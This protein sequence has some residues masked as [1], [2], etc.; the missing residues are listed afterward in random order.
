MDL[1]HGEMNQANQT[2]PAILGTR[3]EA[4]TPSM[5]GTDPVLQLANSA[6]LG[7]IAL[8]LLLLGASGYLF[9]L[10]VCKSLARSGNK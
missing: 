3:A 9:L 4:E 8:G 7:L 6:D 5:H 1:P 2:Q 10:K